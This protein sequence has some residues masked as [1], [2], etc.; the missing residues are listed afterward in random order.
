MKKGSVFLAMAAGLL[1][2]GTAHA[3]GRPY[4]GIAGGLMLPSDSNLANSAGEPER[5]SYKAGYTI[6][7]VVGIRTESGFRPEAELAYK[8]VDMDQ[9]KYYNLSA[10]LKADEEVFAAMA[11]VF[12]DIKVSSHVFPYLGG[13]IGVATYHIDHAPTVLVDNALPNG[14]LIVPKDNDTVFAYQA[15][16]GVNVEI[17]RH[18]MVDLGYRYFGFDSDF[19]SHNLQVGVNYQ[20]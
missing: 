18:V 16:A 9:F 14:T 20:F 13:G 12:Y 1:L 8:A 6:S 4:I 19:E 17:S 3:A 15:G 10:P 11:N 5:V 7:G 2:T